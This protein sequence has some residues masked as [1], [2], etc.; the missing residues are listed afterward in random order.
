MDDAAGTGRVVVCVYYGDEVRA[1]E[2]CCIT[3]TH[4]YGG[5]DIVC[6]VS[7]TGCIVYWHYSYVLLCESCYSASGMIYESAYRRK[8]LCDTSAYTDYSG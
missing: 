8:E 7:G 2:T 6:E 5:A 3:T 4:Y 1:T